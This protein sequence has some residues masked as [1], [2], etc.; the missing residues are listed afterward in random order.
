[1]ALPKLTTT[2]TA[3]TV[4][5][6]AKSSETSSD[7]V[8]DASSASQSTS[9]SSATDSTAWTTP[10][11]TVPP[12]DS[13]PF[14]YQTQAPT[15]T[16][17]IC[18][19]ALA[20]L[21]FLLYAFI[22]GWKAWRSRKAAKEMD[23]K[24]RVYHPTFMGNRA[25]SLSEPLINPVWSEQG[26]FNNAS[27]YDTN[28]FSVADP[29]SRADVFNLGQVPMFGH[30][31]SR[32]V[33]RLTSQELESPPRASSSQSPIRERGHRTLPSVNLENLLNDL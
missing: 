4:T 28:R 1:M 2:A 12:M 14:I 5:E 17:F 6:T 18:L 22:M 31:R 29:V 11:V 3:A 8:S 20:A 16:V 7:T 13:N 27:I 19:G 10:E 23:E 25:S 15:G 21:I 26:R 32:S 9:Q 30:D 33:I 24:T